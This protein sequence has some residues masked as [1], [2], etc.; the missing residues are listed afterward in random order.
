MPPTRKKNAAQLLLPNLYD[1]STAQVVVIPQYDGLLHRVSGYDD[2]PSYEDLRKCAKHPLVKLALDL[3][4]GEL[5][6][7]PWRYEINQEIPP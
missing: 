6:G 1:K 5:E 2:T 7:V 4:A 3:L